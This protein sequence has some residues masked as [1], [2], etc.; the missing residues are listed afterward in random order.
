[1]A[2]T[3]SGPSRSQRQ[4]SLQELLKLNAFK[5]SARTKQAALEKKALAGDKDAAKSV[6]RWNNAAATAAGV[7]R[8]AYAN[9]AKAAFGGDQAAQSLLQR[10]N[11]R[12]LARSVEYQKGG[13]VFAGKGNTGLKQPSD[14]G[15]GRVDSVRQTAD[16]AQKNGGTAGKKYDW[17]DKKGKVH[18]RALKSD[19]AKAKKVK[20]P[21]NQTVRDFSGAAT[22]GAARAPSGYKIQG[23]PTLQFNTQPGSKREN[24]RFA[25]YEAKNDKGKSQVFNEYRIGNQVF[26]VRAK[27]KSTQGP[28]VPGR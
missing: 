20:T 12:G 24:L 15:K 22:V 9:T 13:R 6:S 21:A 8:N 5:G 10:R 16:S 18:S 23:K 1:M 2:T 17:G 19:Q 14:K 25:Q 11:I 3:S 4:K 7:N 27:K 26:R 28:L